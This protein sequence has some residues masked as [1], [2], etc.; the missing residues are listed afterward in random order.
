[1]VNRVLI[2]IKVVQLLYAY[3]LSQ[4]EFRL[5]QPIENPSRDKKFAYDLYL[6]VL[7]L[8]LELS[9]YTPAE[10]QEA[11]PLRNVNPK[12]DFKTLNLANALNSNTDM[13]RVFYNA[14]TLPYQ[15]DSI[16]PAIYNAVKEL[17]AYKS[18]VKNSSRS[19][20][21][22]IDLWKSIVHN[23]MTVNPAFIEAA[24]TEPGF[25]MAGFEAAMEMVQTTL[26]EY[27]DNRSLV[28]RTRKS[29]EQSLGKAHELYFRLLML[30]PE[31]TEAQARRLDD[32]RNKY[33]PT[34]ADLHPDTR[35]VDNKFVKAL[36]ANPAYD[37]FV[38]KNKIGWNDD[39]TID[40]LLDAVLAS[41]EYKEYMA[42]TGDKTLEQDAALWRDLFNSV[43]LPSD[44]LA[45]ALE[46][47]SV[48]WN[49][50]LHEIGS[51]V[52][53]TIRRFGKSASEVAP[54]ATPPALIL[55]MY[56]DEEDSKMGALI[57]ENAVKN[58]DE[59]RQLI[60]KF[61]NTSR[62]DTDRLAFMDVVIIIAAIAEL[63]VL[64]GVPLAVTFNEYIEIANYYSTPRSGAFINGIL[65]SVAN[66]LNEQ[67]IIFKK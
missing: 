66:Y 39:V 55:P 53:K 29:L 35:F 65:Y 46:S 33:M 36:I 5:I 50:D 10:R 16:L 32:A 45:E 37:E 9:G 12:A 4:N 22:E 47:Q 7:M 30:A 11:S 17:P 8:I 44:I 1:M 42:S 18:F 24:R 23:L 38:T 49:D 54:G 15:F 48:Y 64:P 13:R 19:I 40:M 41:E 2:R 58:Y 62:W 63:I 34:D 67:G 6:D 60:D 61:V 14:N 51:F 59:Y 26:S 31:I 57:F 27:S 43:I 28:T 52:T 56:K 20:V 3:L 25:T 21:E